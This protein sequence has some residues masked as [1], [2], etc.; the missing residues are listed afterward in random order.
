MSVKEHFAEFEWSAVMLGPGRAGLAVVAAAPSGITGV[1]AELG[2]MGQVIRDLVARQ[3][4][5][6]LLQAISDDLQQHATPADTGARAQ[7]RNFTEVRDEAL[8]G[9][10]Q[11][12]WLVHAKS[13]PEDVR[14]YGDLL[15]DIARRTAEAAREGGFLGFGGEQVNDAERATIAD[16]EAL[17]RPEPS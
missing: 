14:A 2:A 8:Q 13:T 5:T 9:V 16:I 17:V 15:L 3:P 4:K 7:G 10:R 11:A 1:L 6:P 12:M